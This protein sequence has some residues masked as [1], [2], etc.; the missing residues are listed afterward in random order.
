MIRGPY[1]SYP[2][3][4]VSEYKRILQHGRGNP[5]E[6]DVFRGRRGQRGFGI[7]GGMFKLFKSAIEPLQQLIVPYMKKTGKK[8][9]ARALDLGKDVLLEGKSPRLALK[10]R[11][12][13]LLDDV[14]KGTPFQKLRRRPVQRGKG[15]LLNRNNPEKSEVTKARKELWKITGN[16]RK[17]DQMSDRTLPEI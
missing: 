12:N 7:F 9:A 8:A 14:I 1:S 16:K 4:S 11:G 2:S 5:W 13:Q 15:F 10:N 17:W 3:T 6:N